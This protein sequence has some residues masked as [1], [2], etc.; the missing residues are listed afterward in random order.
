M[1]LSYTTSR[2]ARCKPEMCVR[3]NG[4]T[5]RDE[6]KEC[7]L[8][9][10]YHHIL[11]F[12][13]GESGA[14]C[15]EARQQIIPKNRRPTTEHNTAV[16]IMNANRPYFQQRRNTAMSQGGLHHNFRH[17]DGHHPRDCEVEPN[18][19]PEV[20]HER[21]VFAKRRDIWLETKGVKSHHW[22]SPR[23]KVSSKPLAQMEMRSRAFRMKKNKIK[24][25]EPGIENDLMR[26]A[27]VYVVSPRQGRAA[28]VNH[29]VQ[30]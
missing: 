29:D 26:T 21:R 11:H 3:H 8:T 28:T 19:R 1:R 25:V 13:A 6:K 22:M 4:V 24:A 14:T 17:R 20:V 18:E 16:S 27:L 9:D 5:Q 7:H 12:G 15:L 23:T 30:I 10:E 2:M